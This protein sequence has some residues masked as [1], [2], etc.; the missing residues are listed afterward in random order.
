MS[1]LLSGLAVVAF[2][3][4][5]LA[6]RTARQAPLSEARFL[7]LAE[8]MGQGVRYERPEPASTVASPPELHLVPGTAAAGRAAGET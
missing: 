7:A 8:G 6:R 3:I 5:V 2:A 4:V 1:L